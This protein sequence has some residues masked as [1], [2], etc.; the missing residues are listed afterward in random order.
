MGKLTELEQWD[1]DI[2][3]IET[4]DPVLGGP[5]G[6]SNRPQKQLAN[7]TQ[8]LKK[9]LE[10]ANN[11]LAEHEKS[12]NHP[13][14]TLTDK[15][16]VKLYSGVT[17]MDE[18]MAA[19]PKAVKI[20]MD[21]ANERLAKARN[22]ADLQSVPL[23]LANLTLA[24]VKKYVESTNTGVSKLPLFRPSSEDDLTSLPAGYMALVK[25]STPGGPLPDENWFYLE[26]AGNLDNSSN[27]PNRK[28][29]VIRLIQVSTPEISWT[30]VKFDDGTT[31][32]AKFRWSRDFNTLNK[33]TPEDVGLAATK[34]AIDDTQTGF[35]AQ[36]VMWVTSA[37]DLS[38]L[39]SG[40][41]RFASN[42]APATVLPAAGYFFLE[43][44]S[45]RDV[46][47]GSCILATSDAGNVWIGLR[48]TAP[49]DT[50]F[51]W[52]Q[53]NQ[54]VENL[55]LTEA[56]K[57]A[58]NAVQKNG[59]TMSAPLINTHM[60]GFRLKQPGRSFFWRFDG[61]TLYLLR[62]AINDPDGTWD[63][64][65]PLY[66]NADSGQVFLGPNT[67]VNGTLYVDNARVATDGN[68]YGT[69]WNTN[70]AW[71]WDTIA[72]QLAA[73]DNNINARA[74]VD[75]VNQTFVRD[76]RAGNVESAQVWRAYGYNDQAPYVITGV[77]N[78]NTDDL[79]DSLTR[80]PLQKNINGVWY[81]I[82]FI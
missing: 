39:P 64:A 65:R 13:D 60:N 12:R 49:T 42:K 1:E 44:L 9:Q 77:I 55:G 47:N 19:T 34:K 27:N 40:A 58:N 52:I 59:D 68:I 57:R 30:G 69:R 56:V 54:N 50:A 16:F 74:T 66:V 37:D 38:N 78:G 43:V 7:R 8:W 53:L 2:Y 62:T 48:Y 82:G 28:G 67:K 33:P 45:K 63:A 26:V 61:S 21:N 11:A 46:A 18:T 32:T 20:A 10:D 71:L 72:E 5:E 35:A 29:A 36:G 3:Q 79:I 14:A 81:N 23:A 73:R 6:L 4:S 80:R 15:G 22:L 25:N 41:H 24:N 17:S 75:Y 31:T 51:T 70:G 76:V